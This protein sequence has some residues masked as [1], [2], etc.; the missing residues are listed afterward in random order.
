MKENSPLVSV[1]LPYYNDQKTI[2]N[3]VKS[4]LRQSYTNFELI[5]FNHCSTDKSE[6]IVRKFKDD[7]IIYKN[8][9]RNLGAGSGMNLQQN[10][11]YMHGK[12]IKLFCADDMLEKTYL[13]EMVHFMECNKQFDFAF[14][15][16]N[17]IDIKGSKIETDWG[18]QHKY[19]SVKNNSEQ[20]LLI[21]F[22]GYSQLPFPSSI[23]KRSALDKISLNKTYIMLFD[24]S[25][26]VELLIEGYKVGYLN[27]HLVRYR[28][29][30]SQLSSIHNQ[31]LAARRGYFELSNQ[32]EQ[33]YA[34]RSLTFIKKYCCTQIS[35]KLTN[36]DEVF[37][38]LAIAL[39]YL[40]Q[41]DSN[42]FA[43]THDLRRISGYN[44]I[45]S[46]MEND[47]LRKAVE[48]KFGFYIDTFR[49]CYSRTP[50]KHINETKDI[51]I[52]HTSII[53]NI[54]IRKKI[55]NK[56]TKSLAILEI[57]YII[58]YKIFRIPYKIYNALPQ[59]NK[60]GKNKKFTV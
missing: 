26:W 13:E 19:F 39:F 8:G 1:F 31:E 23:I 5:L 25:L 21:F 29:S 15:E 10:L 35:K 57:C 17:Y 53:K 12:Y 37:F 47:H 32:L 60:N 46:F 43:D 27:R 9:S 40:N 24:V 2:Y 59:K 49:D 45:V 28:C 56:S 55:L 52:S 7:R 14:S 33:F 18:K 58:I 16:M 44:K 38:P 3:C 22:K 11:I 51:N 50:F 30:S 48:S 41:G 20:T 4:I 6:E 54:F 34:I 42:F 36:K